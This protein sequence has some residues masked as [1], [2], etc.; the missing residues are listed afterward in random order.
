V[1]KKTETLAEM[2][3]ILMD[4]VDYIKP[5]SSVINS[6]QMEHKTIQAPLYSA[7]T[8]FQPAESLANLNQVLRTPLSV[9]QYAQG[10]TTVLPG[11]NVEVIL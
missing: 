1:Q 8:E 2:N 7:D 10:F 9:P 4:E 5:I 11:R 6:S 3:H